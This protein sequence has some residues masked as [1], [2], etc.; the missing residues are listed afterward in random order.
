MT[1]NQF[2]TSGITPAQILEGISAIALQSQQSVALE[3]ILQTALKTCKTLLH[4]DRILLYRFLSEGGGV[5][6]FE[7]VSAEWTSLLGQA[8]CDACFDA[9]RL[10]RYRQGHYSAIDDVAARD[11]P[12]CYATLLTR[13]QVQATLLVPLLVEGTVWGLLIAHHCQSAR[14]WHPLEVQCLQMFSIQL[15]VAMQLERVDRGSL[16]LTDEPNCSDEQWLQ[17]F[18]LQSP[19][20]VYTLV[21]EPDRSL[22]F[23]FIST[24]VEVLYE[25]T[26][27]QVLANAQVLL[28]PIHPD[29]RAGY[30]AAVAQSAKTLSTF[31]YEWQIVVPSG[32]VKW[33]QGTAHPKLRPHGAIVWCGVVQE[34]SERKRAEVGLRESEAHK[35]ALISALPDLVMRI[36][37]HGIYLEFLATRTFRVIGKT[38]DFVGTHVYDSLPPA[39]AQRRMEAIQTALRTQAI[40]FYEQTLSVDGEIQT[41]EVRV[42]PYQADEV[43]LLV[44]DISDRN[45][46]EMALRQHIERE[47]SIGRVVQAIRQ[48]LDLHTILTAA[49][50]EIAQL[51]KVDQAAVVQY[52]PERQCWQHV[53]IYKQQPDLPNKVGL[54]VPDAGNPIAAQLKRRE[55][56]KV[57]DTAQLG[58]TINQKIAQRLPGAWLLAPVIVGN[59]VWGSFS[60]LSSQ[61]VTH[62]QDEQVELVQILADQLAIAIQQAA[63]YQQVQTLNAELELQVQERTAQLQ[64]A[65]TFEALLKRITDHVRDSLDEAQILQTAVK[66]LAIELNVD[67]CDATLFDIERRT[68]NICYEYIHEGVSSA[69][70]TSISFDQNPDLYRQVLSREVVHCCVTSLVV[71]PLRNIEQNASILVCPLMDE[72]GVLGDMWLFRPPHRYFNELEIRLVQQVANQCAI[73]LRQSRLYQ[74]SQAQVH[75]L[76]RLN[77]LKDDFLSTVSHELRTPMSNIKMA[78]QMLEITLKPLGVFDR[79][80]DPINRYFNVLREEGQRE[81]GLINDLLDLARLDAGTEPLNLTTIALQPFLSHLAE[82]FFERT[83]KQ[84][85]QLILNLPDTLPS[86]T[87]DQSYLERILTEL[88]QNAYKYTPAGENIILGAGT[89]STALEIWTRNSGIEIPA[90]ERDRIF[91]KFYRIPNNDPWKYEGTGLGLT[92]AKKLAEQL[93]ASLYV[94]SHDN[95][96]TFTLEFSGL[97]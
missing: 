12:A 58:N 16:S 68:T 78:T 24:A 54:E 13:L 22:W 93:G 36:N 48:S 27:T 25:V 39:L 9:V 4:S 85:Q 26:Q 42:V 64:Q 71:D 80:T 28:D 2:A 59:V 49:A 86:L 41:E 96:T 61:K 84:Q 1:V 35:S 77:Q 89:T 44:R 79:E 19:G 55:I 32:K 14:A 18:S 50:T 83:R 21:Q 76:E 33:L 46:A 37:Q 66:E 20:I 53:A 8:I 65:L 88:L 57:V 91:D 6:A 97:V 60:L 62:W 72:R 51:L 74:A 87:T 94:T 63:L 34:I 47:Q 92:L 15:G 5:V 75:E 69:V 10:E 30:A 45:Q 81:I 67:C 43:L 3:T 31:S 38:G 23:E 73:A 52:L 40:Q 29:D 7:A 56:V 70:G 17:Q 95:Q 82:P 90:T 11:I